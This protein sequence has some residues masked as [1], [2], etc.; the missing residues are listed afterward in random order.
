MTVSFYHNQYMKEIRKVLYILIAMFVV[1]PMWASQ[2]KWEKASALYADK[3]YEGA[4]AI[5]RELLNSGESPELYYNYA[6]TLYKTGNLGAAVLN[7]ERA[8]RLDPNNEDAR[9]NLD[10][11]NSKITDKI[12]PVERFFLYDWIDALGRVLTTNQWAWMSVITFV[13]FLSLALTYLFSRRRWLRKSAFFVAL[14]LFVVSVLSFA[15]AFST[16]NKLDRRADAIVMSGTVSVKSSP[17]DGGTELFVLH[18]GTK[19]SIISTL[20]EWGEIRIADGNVGWMLLSDVE[21]I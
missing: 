6:N 21:R 13:L 11:V 1:L 10:F 5:Y 20:G 12:V 8:L 15:Y 17:D 19:V 16:K 18:E 14:S 4:A 9:F 7:Y 3:D 2:D